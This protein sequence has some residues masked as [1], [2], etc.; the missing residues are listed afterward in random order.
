MVM[1]RKFAYGKYR[2]KQDAAWRFLRDE[3]ITAL[4]VPMS[5]PTRQLGIRLCGY[6]ANTDLLRRSGLGSLLDADGFAY[7]DLNGKLAIFYNDQRSR[8]ESRFTIAHELGHILLEHM[9]PMEYMGSSPQNRVLSP[10]DDRKEQEADQFALR[11]LA[12]ACVLWAKGLYTPEEIAEACDISPEAA[13]RR[14]RR[15]AVLLKRDKFLI[16]DLERQVFG[17]FGLTDPRIKSTAP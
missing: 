3:R 9:G 8:Q 5:S 13:R 4:P 14:A 10:Q 15:M 7:M 12:P 1:E 17:Q 2:K 16:K 6:T 11:V